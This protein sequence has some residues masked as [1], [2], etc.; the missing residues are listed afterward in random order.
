MKKTVIIGASNNP[1]RY[2]FRAA[3]LLKEHGHQII[4]VSNKKGDVAGENILNI[5]DTPPVEDVDTVTMYV[6]PANQPV[7]HD[8]ILSLKPKRI[9]FN[10]GT[11]NSDFERKA[12]AKGI[13]TYQHC[14][15]V[16]LHTGQY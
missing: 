2:S 4:P 5:K 13:Q 9:I 7:Y 8:Y 3:H 11:E 10:P 14:T 1:S 16:L 15:L 12:R 6:G